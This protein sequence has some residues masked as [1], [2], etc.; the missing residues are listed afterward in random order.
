MN[1]GTTKQEVLERL[2]EFTKG[3][4]HLLDLS[5][6]YKLVLDTGYDVPPG[7]LH[8]P[9][10][11]CTYEP[12]FASDVYAMYQSV[13]MNGQVLEEELLWKNCPREEVGNYEYLLD[14]IDWELNVDPDFYKNRFMEPRPVSDRKEMEGYLEEWIC[15]KSQLVCAKRLIVYPGRTVV[16][17]DNAAYGVICIQGRGK[18]GVYPIESPTQIR[19]EQLTND[20][21]FVTEH[22]A[23]EGICITNM[24]ECENLVIL[25]HFAENPDLY[26]SKYIK[27]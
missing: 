5:R 27:K 19:Y 13:L 6:A 3:D 14:V 1:P 25:K 21:Y 15:Y 7:V 16:I 8:A 10:S 17:R 24:S 12:Q 20:E 26:K 11:L 4:N 9:G 23:K 2:K 18:F 22:A